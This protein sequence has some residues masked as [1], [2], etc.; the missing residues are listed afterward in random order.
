ME[1][2]SISRF[3]IARY[4]CSTWLALISLT[5]TFA[6]FGA[7]A[8]AATRDIDIDDDPLFLVFDTEILHRSELL[9]DRGV[10]FH[11]I[12]TF[13]PPGYDSVQQR[14]II[15][16]NGS[17]IQGDPSMVLVRNWP[18]WTIA[19]EQPVRLLLSDVATLTVPDSI[20]PTACGT[21]VRNDTGFVYRYVPDLQLYEEYPVVVGANRLGEPW[22]A[23][24]PILAVA[25]LDRDG[26]D[27]LM[28][29]ISAGRYGTPRELVCVDSKSG[30]VRWRY[31]LAAAINDQSL[32]VFSEEPRVRF[33]TIS[34]GQG[35]TVDGFSDMF[36]YYVALDSDGHERCRKI[37]AR[38]PEPGL[39]AWDKESD[40][41]YLYHTL[42]PTDTMSLSEE[43]S[44][45][46]RVSLI[47]PIGD[48]RIQAAIDMELQD[49]WTSDYIGGG[50]EELCVIT[51]SGHIRV[52]DSLLSPVA[53]S[54]PSSLSGFAGRGPTLQ[55]YRETGV[56][57]DQ[58][59]SSLL[60]SESF[61]P[62]AVLPMAAYV[63][64]IQQPDESSDSATLIVAFPRRH[65]SIV[66]LRARSFGDYLVILF[67]RYRNYL[68]AV[69]LS[70]GVGLVIVNYYRIRTRRNL[71]T[72]STQ[73][74][75]LEAA[76]RALREAQ[77]QIVAAEKYRQAK[78]IAGGLAHEIRN[79][80]F[81]ARGL[82]SRLKK[83]QLGPGI[84]EFVADIERSVVRAVDVT[85]W[86]SRYTTL[87]SGH[88]PSLVRIER[89]VE[90]VLQLHGA[91]IES[92][93]VKVKTHGDS[94]VTVEA[95][96][97][98]LVLAVSNLV[99]NSLDA[100]GGTKDPTLSIGWSHSESHCRIAVE[101]SGP[102]IDLEIIA[103]VFD[104]FFSTKPSQGTGLGLCIVRQIAT[105]H[106]GSVAIENR[107]EGGVRAEIAL[108]AES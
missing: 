87:D 71:D 70:L 104:P 72:I 59:G 32:H 26:Y 10:V 76:H 82:L 78:D 22:I 61:D 1:S 8:E 74:E 48:V 68:I 91:K 75:E 40:R 97:A 83:E 62:L 90:Q 43:E 94:A 49:M 64:L 46:P 98:Q 37:V 69:L 34:P 92:S 31:G 47:S 41:A 21:G 5:A 65:G 38:Y 13:P 58:R 103:R 4:R 17:G 20:A 24:M 88:A 55:G 18:E 53:G 93:G 2:S 9:D 73:K 50:C 6:L 45:S 12:L 52:Y 89:I 80:L 19:D 28:I 51:N 86:I 25:D 16:F 44:T 14:L 108:P 105:L 99:G 63:A 107:P 11:P 56:L 81:P 77:E 84:G 60:V 95:D 30:R 100:L 23:K 35:Y 54:G 57:K 33:V 85:T 106:G 27:E 67:N 15:A 7:C 42:Q 39:L 102:G 96:E 3:G 29:G 79:A 36:S 66:S 101:D